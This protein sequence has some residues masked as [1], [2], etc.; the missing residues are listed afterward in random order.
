MN[1]FE[2]YRLDTV[3]SRLLGKG[4]CSIEF[5]DETAE[6]TPEEWEALKKH[7][8]DMKPRDRWMFKIMYIGR[9]AIPGITGLLNSK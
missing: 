3:K 6:I 9:E 8:A 7:V 5:Q 2:E 1:K 4:T